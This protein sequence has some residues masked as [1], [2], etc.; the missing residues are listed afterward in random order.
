MVSTPSIVA[1]GG[2][3]IAVTTHTTM[4]PDS[5]HLMQL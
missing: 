4:F 5:W 2:T 1:P 3:V